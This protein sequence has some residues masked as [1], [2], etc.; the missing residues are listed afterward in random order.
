M[1]VTRNLRIILLSL[2]LSVSP[3]QQ[4]TV[5]HHV[6]LRSTLDIEH[7]NRNAAQRSEDHRD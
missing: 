5:L 7:A 1:K 3:Q 4:T 6:Y 2:G